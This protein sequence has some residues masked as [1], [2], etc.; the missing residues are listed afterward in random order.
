MIKT[1][2]FFTSGTVRFSESFLS[3]ITFLYTVL[4]IVTAVILLTDMF[5]EAMVLLKLPLML[6]LSF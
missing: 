6:V 1:R 5:N 4:K 3:L 2:F